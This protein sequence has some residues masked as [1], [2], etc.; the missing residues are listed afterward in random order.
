MAAGERTPAFDP[1]LSYEGV[2]RRV[3]RV[4]LAFPA[5][6]GWWIGFA[7]S[8]AVVLLLLVAIAWLFLYGVGI[9][10]IQM[11]VP[12]GLAI[13]NYVW[14]IGMGHAGTLIS[15]FLL[16]TNRG[17]RNSLNRFAEAMTVFAVICA[18]LYP[19]LHLGRPW[20]FYW[21]LPYPNVMD[22][23]PQ[24]RSPLVWD[25]FAVGTYLIVSV[26]FWY[27]G[28]IPDLA[29]MRD[30]A[31]GRG[32]KIF[33]GILC[34]GWRGAARH[35]IRWQRAYWIVAG[36]A[37]PLVV[38]VH[39]G[40]SMLFAVGLEP[41]WHSTLFPA[42]FVIGAIFEGFA[43]VILIALV[44]RHAFGWR[45]LVTDR[46][47]D[48]LA[49]ILLGTGL[50]TTFGY[51]FEI[52]GAWYSGDAFERKTIVDRAIGVYA[53][54]FWAMVLFN[55]AAI[56]LLWP[57]RLRRNLLVL[58]GVAALVTL[59]MWFERFMLVASTLYRDFLP[60]AWR[61]YWPSWWEWIT[62][63]GMIGLFFFL[64]YLFVRLIPA[65]SMFEVKEV[66]RHEREDRS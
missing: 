29:T 28:L 21:L 27:V 46:H 40:V 64:F 9:W 31:V 10:G 13:V 43:V 19:I 18:A 8:F 14:W 20:L 1:D 2:D 5:S 17:W 6:R 53:W 59:G 47:L 35:W 52:F 61:D 58:G 42:Y 36:L 37:V 26:I 4:P 41:G 55:V 51:L 45:E 23:W 32:W 50:A 33:Y 62:F 16:V 22:L 7:V 49:K 38:S 57:P 63:V 66:L 44:M 34:L 25:V 30:R 15:A 56:Q 65:I 24:F 11:P 48:I 60:S 3:A 54:S 12:W 39:S